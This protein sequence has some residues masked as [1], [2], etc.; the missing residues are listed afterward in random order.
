MKC[1]RCNLQAVLYQQYSGRHLCIEHLIADIEAR[2]KRTIRQNNWLE[3]G[4]R[5]GIVTGLP[6]SS[7]L[8]IF[9][10]HL[11]EKRNDISLILIEIPSLTSDREAQISG[12]YEYL[13]KSGVT[14]I[15]L[16]DCAEDIA[17]E[18]LSALFRGS[19]RSLLSS[20]YS[21][22]P[23]KIMTPFREIPKKELVL[24]AEYHRGTGDELEN[25]E[26]AG[27]QRDPFN[28]E[29]LSLLEQYSQTHPS[30]PHALRRY[31]DHLRSI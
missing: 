30:A 23:M 2:A 25:H 5:I 20:D 14:C 27:I 13:A 3:R 15:A 9:L 31:R 12:V 21:D 28:Q 8:Q 17:V 1:S 11:T 19:L 6:H 29:V 4:C 22:I 10:T 24:Y 7:A 26:L 18:V 16:P